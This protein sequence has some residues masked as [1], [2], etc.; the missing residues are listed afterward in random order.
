VQIKSAKHIAKQ[1]EQNKILSYT[2]MQST[3]AFVA[4]KAA[5][6]FIGAA[7]RNICLQ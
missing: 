6:C 4:A 7:H 3:A 2:Q 1:K 5:Q